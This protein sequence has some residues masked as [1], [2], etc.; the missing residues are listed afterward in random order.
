MGD[1]NNK[2]AMQKKRG[3]EEE[4]NKTREK[5]NRTQSVCQDGTT[6]GKRESPDLF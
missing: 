2:G 3:R 4:K 5:E 6:H 1:W